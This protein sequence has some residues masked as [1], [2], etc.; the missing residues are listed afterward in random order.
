[1]KFRFFSYDDKA[2]SYADP[3]VKI[4]ICIFGLIVVRKRHEIVNMPYL[5]IKWIGILELVDVLFCV[6]IMMPCIISLPVSISELFAVHKNRAP[7]K[8]VSAK[9]LEKSRL[10]PIDEIIS[11]E[12][13]NDIIKIEIPSQGKMVELGSS[14]DCEVDSSKF[15]DK[16]FYVGDHEY[17]SIDD[18][19][20]ELKKYSADGKIRVCR[21]DDLPPKAKGK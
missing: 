7:A 1:M 16:R 2:T 11:L 5:G 21:I 18:F 12:K 13:D 3:I 6:A 14:S 15:F 19:E 20:A 8:E 4:L 9:A 17:I 10:Y